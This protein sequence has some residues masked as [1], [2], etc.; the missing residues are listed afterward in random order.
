M[1]IH[2][3]AAPAALFAVLFLVLAGSRADAAASSFPPGY[4][5]YHT[6]AEMTTQLQTVAAAHPGIVK[7]SSI[8][9]SYQ[10]REIWM[11]KISN[12]PGMD[13]QEPE[14][15]ITGLTHAREHL[16]VEQAL[17][18]ISW[19]VNGYGTNST[20]THIVN[21]TE[22]WVAPMLNPDGGEYDIK[23]GH[24]HSWRK[25]R[26]PTPGSTAIG[27]DINRNFGYHWNCCGGSSSNPFS[28]IY[29]GPKPFST[30][31]ARVE[32]KFVLSRIVN[33]KQQ[34]VLALSLHSFG[35][36]VLYPYGYTRTAVPSDMIP[37]DHAALKALAKGIA[38]R[39]GYIAIQES[40]WYITSGTFLDWSY[41]TQR[42][43]TFTME[44]AP[45]TASGGGFYA[46]GN[47]VAK[48][49]Q[50]NRAALLW[51]IEQAQCPYDAS[52]QTHICSGAA[53][54]STGA[55]AWAAGGAGMNGGAALSPHVMARFRAIPV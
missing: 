31:E 29:H 45:G 12:N 36:R 35:Q 22:I 15:L 5:Q 54:A 37:A 3:R 51:W 8:G 50:H 46:P 20:I 11:V 39:N 1:T 42:I 34:I 49:T 17:A 23:G 53:A 48:L 19:L 40:H 25:N 13:Q 43:L 9:Q 7:L 14:V 16:T 44:M 2:R 52:G 18:V 55:A 24:F 28:D 21:T 47:R 26:Q 32:R 38:S 33:G 4:Q 6:Y 41:G 27:T 30:P 10:G